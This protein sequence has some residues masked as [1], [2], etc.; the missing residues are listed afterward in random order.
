VIGGNRAENN[1]FFGGASDLTGLGI[2]ATGYTT[3]PVGT[4]VAGGN[5]DPAGCNPS[6]L[7]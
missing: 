7:C 5:D 2:Y 1:G 4:N 6:A 3:A